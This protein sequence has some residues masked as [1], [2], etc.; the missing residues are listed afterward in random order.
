MFILTKENSIASQFIGELRNVEIQK[1][2]M[3]FRKNLERLGEILA[4]EVSKALAYS[5]KSVQTPLEEAVVQNLSEQPVLISV[6]RAAVPF[7]QGF[8]NIFDR[9]D[10]GFVGAYRKE[11][12]SGSEKLEIDFLYQAMPN[13]TNRDVILVD[14]ML[15]TGQSF[16]KTVQNLLKNGNPRNIHIVS[17]IAAPEGIAYIQNHV[18]REI[19]FWIGALDKGLNDKFYI[20]PGLGDAGDLSFGPK[21]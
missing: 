4:Y 3:R 16:V 18:G 13:L 21:V 15:A 9:A 14:P 1:D 10:S 5:S 19:H 20:V 17:V 7:Y 6:L 11:D 2:R 12:N 8:C